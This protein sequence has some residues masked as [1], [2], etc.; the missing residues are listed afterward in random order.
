MQIRTLS[1]AALLL[2]TGAVA[3]TAATLEVRVSGVAAGAGPVFVGLCDRDLDRDT[4]PI[5]KFQRA[6]GGDVT[7]RFEG[8]QPGRW[9]VAAYQDV[10]ANGSLDMQPILVWQLP[11][12]P[13]G[14]SNDV[15]RYGPPTFRGAAFDLPPSG[16][17]V[18]VRLDRLPLDDRDAVERAIQRQNQ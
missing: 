2:A 1:L 7:F 10:N 11:S 12:E 3:S 13:Y 6:S 14:F 17:S 16:G 5:G 4:C 9:A 15:G 18:A 8:V